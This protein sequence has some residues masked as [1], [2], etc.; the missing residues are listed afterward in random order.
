MW[1]PL[2]DSCTISLVTNTPPIIRTTAASRSS[3]GARLNNNHQST[4]ATARSTPESIPSTTSGISAI[5]AS[6]AI[7]G[8]R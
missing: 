7:R 8:T 4:I 2:I 5:S 1:P 6:G 3:Q